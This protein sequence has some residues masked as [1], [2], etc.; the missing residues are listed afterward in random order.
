MP[1]GSATWSGLP[2]VPRSHLAAGLVSNETHPCC[3]DHLADLK[4][5]ENPKH[6]KTKILQKLE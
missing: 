5:E 2:S 3:P 6:K 4:H 1:F